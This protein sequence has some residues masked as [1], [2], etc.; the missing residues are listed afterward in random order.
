MKIGCYADGN[1]MCKCN[2]CGKEFTGNKRAISCLDCAV[3]ALQAA[4]TDLKAKLK[5][6]H[7]EASQEHNRAENCW[8]ALSKE[9][10][11]HNETM[12]KLA[13]AEKRVAE[14]EAKNKELNAEVWQL[15]LTPISLPDATTEMTSEP[16]NF[17]EGKE[18]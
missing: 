13:E 16:I 9:S 8:D 6:A 3:K 18:V 10:K 5:I 17:D 2:G 14:L 15:K 11:H 1:Y 7:K 4:N 12:E